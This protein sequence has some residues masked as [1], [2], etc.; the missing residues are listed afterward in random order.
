MTVLGH[1]ADICT[2][3]TRPTTTTIGSII[4]ETDTLSY[5]WWNGTDWEGVIPVGTLQA[6]AGTTAPS[7]WLFCFGQSLNATSTPAYSLLFSTIGT[8]YGGSGIAA[9]SMPDLR[10]RAPYGKDNMGGTAASRITSGVSAITG[11]SLCAS[12]GQQQL[13]SHR[14]E[15][16]FPL[17]TSDTGSNGVVPYLPWNTNLYGYGTTKT[18]ANRQSFTVGGAEGSTASGY[19]ALTNN[20]FDTATNM[21]P[22][23][24]TNYIIKY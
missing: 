4:F 7:G 16:S 6:F 15:Q 23:I 5:R 13:A 19:A 18:Y 2:S 20:P 21:P 9:F 12:G 22:T 1:G 3:T 14:H 11:T 8:T 17:H 24:I 10:G